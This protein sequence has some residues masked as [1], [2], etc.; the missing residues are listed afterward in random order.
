MSQARVLTLE[1]KVRHLQAQVDSLSRTVEKVTCERDAARQEAQEERVAH[2]ATKR[3]LRDLYDAVLT[4][5]ER[6]QVLI[7]RQFGAA[8]EQLHGDQTYIPACLD[9][10]DEDTREAL[11]DL[12]ALV[13]EQDAEDDLEGSVDAT[14]DPVTGDRKKEPHDKRSCKRPAHSG[15][16]KP[17]PDDIERCHSD[18]TPPPD[19]PDL[20]GAKDVETIGYA[21]IERL[22][23]SSLR[24]IVEA[25]RC[26][27]VTLTYGQNNRTQVTLAPPALIARG[28]VSDSFVVESALDKVLD[29]LPSYRQS[30]RL[31]RHNVPIARS[32][33]CRW[34]IALAKFLSD[35]T[36]AIFLEI[37]NEPVLGIDDTVHRLLIPNE[38]SCK[39]GRLWLVAGKSGYYYQ[40]HQTREGKWM[41]GLL[42]D[43]TGGVMGDAYAGHNALLRKRG[44]WALFCWAHVR[45]KFFESADTTRGEVMLNLIGQLYAIED[46]IAE[47]PVDQRLDQRHQQAA[48]L[49]AT[50][51]RT[52]DA[53]H[54]NPRILPK[55]GIG[56]AVRYALKLWDGLTSYASCAAAPI[57]NNHTE[58]GMRKN[59]L[60]RKNSLF[61]ASVAGAEAYATLLTITQTALIHNINPN[62]Y[63]NDILE[64]LHFS[65]RSPDQLT[66]MQYAKREKIKATMSS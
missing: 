48:P 12:R 35:I 9:A 58:R 54:D 4:M 32:K 15:G 37:Q 17:L 46:G 36:Q 8:S 1:K 7:R 66:P 26:P 24:L 30:Q 63:L 2:Q 6:L 40:F 28:Q 29:H 43:Y 23:L 38:G 16:R 61:S 44:I 47:L 10:L 62:Q 51:R 56:K 57:D 55:S 45:R 27:I 5:D 18:Y 19:H 14:P 65:R 34:H 52:L 41:E 22:A 31:A 11:T 25:I 13:A 21:H 60:H 53:W 39:Q 42:Q 49:F 64:D 20:V 33:L 3:T 59:A 50:I